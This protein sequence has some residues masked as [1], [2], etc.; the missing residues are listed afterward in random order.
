MIFRNPS[1]ASGPVSNS[2]I[3]DAAQ[4]SRTP[5]K[6][7]CGSTR[8]SRNVTPIGRLHEFTARLEAPTSSAREASNLTLFAPI[9]ATDEQVS[10]AAGTAGGR[11]RTT[12]SRCRNQL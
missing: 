12:H 11:S 5:A 3:D 10:H 6:P 8:H 4:I 7:L 9:V 1:S 2:A